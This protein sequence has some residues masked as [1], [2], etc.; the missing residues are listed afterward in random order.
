MTA[1]PTVSLKVFWAA[2]ALA[3]SASLALISFFKAASCFLTPSSVWV[4][5]ATSCQ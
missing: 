2:A 4:K 1:G 3:S 5:V